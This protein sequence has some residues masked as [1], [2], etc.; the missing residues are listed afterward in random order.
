MIFIQTDENNRV[1]TVLGYPFY[2]QYGYAT[3]DLQ[4]LKEGYFV[5]SLPDIP[6]IDRKIGYYTYEGENIEIKYEDD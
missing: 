5:E 2:V 1:I 3:E 4:K 6:Y